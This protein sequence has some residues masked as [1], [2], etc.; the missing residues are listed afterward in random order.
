MT[1]DVNTK[2]NKMSIGENMEIKWLYNRLLEKIVN[3]YYKNAGFYCLNLKKSKTL[4]IDNMYI[5][6]VNTYS[7]KL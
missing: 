3:F 1:V 4:P 5:E 7:C 6:D 2:T